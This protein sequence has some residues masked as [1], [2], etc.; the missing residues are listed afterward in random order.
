MRRT[1]AAKVK[2]KEIMD[3]KMGV[4]VTVKVK[5]K[6]KVRVTVTVIYSVAYNT[7]TPR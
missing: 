6:V 3:E 2:E 7:T 5:V 4:I 1:I